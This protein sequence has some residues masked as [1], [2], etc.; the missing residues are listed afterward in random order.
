MAHGLRT[1]AA[2]DDYPPELARLTA[3]RPGAYQ[4]IRYG[5]GPEQFGEYWPGGDGA[6]VVL[7]HG[8][9]WRQRYRLDLMNLLAADLNERG[10][11]VWNIEFRRM[12]TPGGG[13][14]GTFDDVAAAL[15]AI[16][17]LD[18]A[19]VDLTRVGV[20][21]HSA[22]GTL[23]LWA[24]R[25][26]RAPRGRVAPAVAVSLAGV[27]DLAL[28]ARLRL[29]GDAV[30]TLL[31]GGP[32][33]RPEAYRQADPAA[34]APL[35]VPQLVVHGTADTHVPHELSRRYAGVAG[36]E[37]TLLSLPGVDHFAV[38][39]PAT[40]AWAR[41]AGELTRLLPADG[42]QQAQETKAREPEAEARTDALG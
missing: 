10:Y 34:C 15:D 16:A 22:G 21:G 42:R 8:G 37:A 25:R 3:S 17:G 40:E 20:I 18:G 30:P 35:G 28:A 19:P 41:I 29:S 13:W 31:G 4:V 36:A 2:A 6:A 39:D 24:A 7:I 9:Y 1:Q 38:I 12:D 27:C 11:A 32:A 14:P 5:P 26:D 23:A 33:D